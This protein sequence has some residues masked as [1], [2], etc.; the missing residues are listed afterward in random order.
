MDGSPTIGDD[1]V[2]DRKSETRALSH[3]FGGEE[4]LE[5]FVGQLL[6]DAGAAVADLGKYIPPIEMR[7]NGDPLIPLGRGLLQG[8]LLDGVPGVGEEIDEDL[9]QAIGVCLDARNRMFQLQD[10]LN[11]PQPELLTKKIKRLQNYIIDLY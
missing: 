11:V 6:G 2:A 5:N 3:G 8:F 1:V 4:R 10:H 9:L 7:S